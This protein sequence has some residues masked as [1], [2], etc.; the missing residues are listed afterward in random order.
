[1]GS[2]AFGHLGTCAPGRFSA[3]RS[4][5]FSKTYELDLKYEFFFQLNIPIPDDGEG[6]PDWTIIQKAW[7]DCQDLIKSYEAQDLYPMDYAMEMR[8]LS[9]SDMLLAP[10]YGNKHGT[11]SVEICSSALVPKDVWEDFKVDLA[12]VWSKYK[13]HKDQP[14]KM[15]PHWAKELPLSVGG[16]DITEYLRQVYSDQMGPFVTT[17]NNILIQNGGNLTDTKMR[18]STKYL[19]TFFGD[20]W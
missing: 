16:Q 8:L 6:N 1:L 12:T 14:L 15:R 10:Y 13:D 17:F 18:F 7:W 5:L 4:P 19:D 2:W 20:M 11:V 9:D 3:P